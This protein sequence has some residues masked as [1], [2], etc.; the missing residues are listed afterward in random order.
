MYGPTEMF[1]MKAWR[2]TPWR[3]MAVFVYVFSV[4]AINY[5]ARHQPPGPK[6][7]GMLVALFMM[8]SSFVL[9]LAGS[10][11]PAGFPVNALSRFPDSRTP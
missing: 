5:P 4:I 2:E 3:S 9:P 6:I 8:L 7:Q 11:L 10:Q 1:I